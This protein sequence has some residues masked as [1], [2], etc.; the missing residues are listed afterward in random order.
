MPLVIGAQPTRWRML[1]YTLALVPITL[2]PVPLGLLGGWYL[3]AALALDAWFVW[4]AVRVLRERT[5]SAARRLFHVSLVYLFALF[6][7]MLADRL[8]A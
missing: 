5:E 2:A 4:H 3:A 8:I 6:L 7:A 1:W